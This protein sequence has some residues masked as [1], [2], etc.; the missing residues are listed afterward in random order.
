MKVKFASV[1]LNTSVK[2]DKNTG[3]QN[4]FYILIQQVTK[5]FISY[6]G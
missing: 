5:T 3:K 2:T 4:R 6:G 1:E